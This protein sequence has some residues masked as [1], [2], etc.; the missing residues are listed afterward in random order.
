MHTHRTHRPDDEREIFPR[1]PHRCEAQYSLVADDGVHWY[2]QLAGLREGRAGPEATS[3]L[4]P[5]K[6]R[7]GRFFAMRASQ[8][9]DHLM[10][11]Y[12]ISDASQEILPTLEKPLVPPLRFNR[13]DNSLES[14]FAFDSIPA[15]IAGCPTPPISCG[16]SWVP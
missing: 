15:N 5:G 1:H 4:K 9:T 12:H 3:R 13:D 7:I 16:V 6:D 14:D 2:G 11:R 10:S 8:T